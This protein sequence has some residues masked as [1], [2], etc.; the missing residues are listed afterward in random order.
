MERAESS[1]QAGTQQSGI[2]SDVP[3]VAKL[4]TVAI[5]NGGLEDE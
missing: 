3:E 1:P 5:T 2:S 4:G